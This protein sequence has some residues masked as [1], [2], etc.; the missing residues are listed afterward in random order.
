MTSSSLP[1]KRRLGDHSKAGPKYPSRPWDVKFVERTS[2]YGPN[3]TEAGESVYFNT[4]T[5]YPTRTPLQYGTWANGWLQPTAREAHFLHRGPPSG[6]VAFQSLDG[7]GYLH[8]NFPPL[9]EGAGW[10]GFW[11]YN[12]QPTYDYD[13]TERA[14]TE[15][16]AKMISGGAQLGATLAESK[17]TLS[18]ISGL[19]LEVL[20]A[21]RAARRGHWKR[22]AEHLRITSHSFKNASKNVSGRWLELQY[23]WKPLLD[24]I[25]SAVE[26]LQRYSTETWKPLCVVRTLEQAIDEELVQPADSYVNLLRVK[27][28]HS[29]RVQLWYNVTDPKL[30]LLAQLGLAN[31]ATVAWELIPYSF[32]VDWFLPVGTYLDA[33]TGMLGCEFLSGTVTTFATGTEN[34]RTDWD[35]KDLSG[36][37]Y[38]VA[39]SKNLVSG[40]V[41]D[42]LTEFPTPSLYLK[43]PVSTGHILNALALIYQRWK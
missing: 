10:H 28:K 22:A 15:A 18:M 24:D 20:Q 11:N 2:Y 14:K 30:H 8:E 1:A 5:V 42:V 36:K 19:S 34:F 9:N 3:G 17:H 4:Y 40:Y 43:S 37:T 23:G 38:G 13:R 29:V 6:A 12:G 31:P 26:T 27:G 25:S 33:W 7:S 39:Y 35:H 21:Y 41:R 32:L 16:L